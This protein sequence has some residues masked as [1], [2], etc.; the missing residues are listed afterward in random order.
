MDDSHRADILLTILVALAAEAKA[1]APS[2]GTAEKKSMP[3]RYACGAS[4]SI[5]QCG[6]GRDA[7]LQAA[8]PPCLPV[9][10][11]VGNIG[12]SGGLAP[13]LVPGTVV[14]GERII[15]PVGGERT[16][17][18]RESYAL[19]RQLVDFLEATLEK[20]MVPCR[21]GPL[22]CTQDP[23]TLPEDK[24]KAFLKTGALAVD[25]ESAAAAEAAVGA[26]LPFF[27]LRVVCDPAD[28]RLTKALFA[29]VDSQGN[30]RPARLLKPLIRRP[31][32]LV[33]LCRMGRD[34]SVALAAMERAWKVIRQPLVQRARR[35][36]SAPDLKWRP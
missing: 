27:V 30:N 36:I 6:I 9:E 10:A 8:A 11:I 15:T 29:G 21:R 26:G 23:I 33:S 19:N 35:Q 14:L 13:D 24:A 1:L 7:V 31:W 34:F 17:R 18:Y 2:S 32:L 4:T 22:L 16:S 5:I 20:N 12:V 3:I 25:L 28:R